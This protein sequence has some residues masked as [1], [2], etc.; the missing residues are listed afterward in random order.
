[1]STKYSYDNFTLPP[2]ILTQHDPYLTTPFTVPNM[3]SV[4]PSSPN[5]ASSLQPRRYLKPRPFRHPQLTPSMKSLSH[6]SRDL[7]RPNSHHRRSSLHNTAAP[8]KSDVYASNCTQHR[9]TDE[10]QFQGDTAIPSGRRSYSCVFRKLSG[11][12]SISSRTSTSNLNGD[13]S[14]KPQRFQGMSLFARAIAP[15]R[16][17]HLKVQPK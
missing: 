1:M 10:K 8:I 9:Y 12:W 2:S 7:T 15:F 11:S 17:E 16:K 3:P 14:A 13:T 5:I 6:H 4:E